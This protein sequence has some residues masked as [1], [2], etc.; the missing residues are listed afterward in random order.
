[1]PQLIAFSIPF[2]SA[3]GDTGIHR[4]DLVDP[5]QGSIALPENASVASAIAHSDHQ[6]ERGCSIILKAV[7]RHFEQAKAFL[8]LI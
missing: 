3:A 5:S 8:I 7:T 4:D 6:F 1:V 2:R